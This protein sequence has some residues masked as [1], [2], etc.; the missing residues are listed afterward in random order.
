[1]TTP[2]QE[3]LDPPH[4]CWSIMAAL[5]GLL[6]P[7]QLVSLPPVY[8]CN[9]CDEMSTCIFSMKVHLIPNITVDHLHTIRH[10][11]DCIF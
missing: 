6:S 1:M 2:S 7:A 9:V 4:P 11:V 10:V 5:Q 3:H 8:T